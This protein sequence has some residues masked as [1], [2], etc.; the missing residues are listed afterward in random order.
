M[1]HH[2]IA[3]VDFEKTIKKSFKLETE[4]KNEFYS[5]KV[6]KF[7]SLNQTTIFFQNIEEDDSHIF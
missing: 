1:Y 5:E 4:L 7:P 2:E 6:G 3:S